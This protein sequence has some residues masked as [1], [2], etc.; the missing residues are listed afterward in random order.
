VE[1][2]SELERIKHE[3]RNALLSIER[4]RKNFLRESS[5]YAKAQIAMYDRTGQFLLRVEQA[6]RSQVD[7]VEDVE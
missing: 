3:V 4:E 7:G 5:I 1:V 2:P 6:L